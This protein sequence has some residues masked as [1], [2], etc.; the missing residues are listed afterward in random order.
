MA[1]GPYHHT[2]EITQTM[3]S[4]KSVVDKDNERGAEHSDTLREGGG[5]L[6]E[7]V[8]SLVQ[9]ELIQTH[10]AP[11]YSPIPGTGLTYVVNSDNDILLDTAKHFYYL[12]LSGRWYRSPRWQ[13]GPW[14]YVAADSLPAD[15]SLI[16]EGSPKDNVLAS[17]AGTEAAR[18]ALL[19]ACIPQ[20]ARIRRGTATTAVHYDVGPKFAP[21]PGTRLQYAINSL[22]PVFREK[23]NYYCVDRG[24]WFSSPAPSGP[25]AA[26][27]NRPEDIDLIPA[28]CPVFYCRFV[29]IYGYDNDF[30][31]TGYTAGYLN[32]YV[33]GNTV[34]YGTGYAYPAWK[35]NDYYPRPQTWG[36]GMQYSPWFGWCLGDDAGLDWL[37]NSTAW[38]VG[39]WSG[40]WWG[41]PGYRPPYIWHHFS[42]HGTYEWDMRRVENVNYNND[43]YGAFRP[44][45]SAE[46]ALLYLDRSG[47]VCRRTAAGTWERR[48]GHQWEPVDSGE[49]AGLN[50]QLQQTLR[51]R[52]RV[53][54]FLQ[55]RGVGVWAVAP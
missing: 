53:Q 35:D 19:D 54:N 46:A 51:G 15:F 31:Y 17:V 11:V 18:E 45:A 28:D 21:I 37:N 41:P 5:G 2:T 50:N 38:G 22:T 42:G 9:A 25:W 24:V 52:M 29:Y 1:E 36:F 6:K 26:C 34:V 44:A 8:I 20:T 3:Q 33:D 13:G 30:I 10:G 49:V 48:A 32:A 4:V 27:L 23:E 7:V 55:Q 16:P 39:Y 47:S 40:G 14:S 43:L 12:L